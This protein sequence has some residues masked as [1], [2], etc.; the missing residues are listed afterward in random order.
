MTL[1]EQDRLT[2]VSTVEGVKPEIAA[3]LRKNHQD[4]LARNRRR[5]KAARQDV[6]ALERVIAM[7]E[8]ALELLAKVNA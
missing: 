1:S 6:A 4:D 7:R 2:V 3:A 8:L 5:L